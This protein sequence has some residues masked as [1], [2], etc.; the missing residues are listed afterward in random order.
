MIRKTILGAGTVLFSVLLSACQTGGAGA[1]SVSVE[2]AKRITAGF[3]G[4]YT[5]PPKSIDDIVSM[6]AEVEL[7]SEDCRERRNW[8]GD[9]V[10][11]IMQALP[12]FD[13][14]VWPDRS[15][16]AEGEAE[17]EFQKGNFP[18]SVK[19]MKWAIGAIPG[20][21]GAGR[22][23]RYAKLAIYHARAGDFESADEALSDALRYA[24]NVGAQ[25]T[26]WS[27][28]VGAT[29]FKFQ[30]DS[31]R[32]AILL[33]KGELARAEDLQRRGIEVVK[34]E[35]LDRIYTIEAVYAETDLAINLMRQG[36]LVEAESVARDVLRR[37]TSNFLIPAHVS[38]PV[39]VRLTQ[40]LFEQG[41]FGDSQTL[42]REA[43]KLYG[44]VCASEGSLGLAIARDVLGKSLVAQR[45]WQEALV[46]YEAIRQGLANDPETFRSKFAG[47][48]DWA[49]ALLYVG[50][51]D[52][53]ASMLRTALA[54]NE[55]RLGKKHYRTAEVRGFVAVVRAATGDRDGALRGFAAATPILLSR[56]READD[57][58]STFAIRDRR[59]QLILESYM[60][61]L[62]DN[63]GPAL[64]GGVDAAAEAF[65]LADA[66]RGRSVQRALSASAAR[67]AANDPA[68]ADLV[69]R[70]QDAQKQIAA[71]YGL[72]AN[73]VSLP[74]DEQNPKVVNNLRTRIDQLR[75]ARAAL[76]EEIDGRFPDYAELINPKPA[77]VADA[78]ASLSAGEAL[79][80]TYVGEDRSYVW[81]VPHRGDVAFAGIGLGR[82]D[83]ADTVALLRS[84]LE[85]NAATL[86]DIPDFDVAE[87]YG[88]Y[89]KLLKPVE[90]GWK[91]ADS[92]LVVAHGPLGYLP[93]SVLPTR[94]ADLGEEQE[95]LFS[96]YR[97]VPWLARNH[98]VTMLPSVASLKTLRGAAAGRSGP[99]GLRR[100]RRPLLQRRAGGG[101]ETDGK[102]DADC[103]GGDPELAHH[104][105]SG[106]PSG[107]AP[108]GRAGER[109][110]GAAS[111]P[112]G[113]RRRG[114]FHRRGAQRRP[115]SRCL[116]R[117][118]GQ[119]RRGED[120]RPVG[121]QGSCLRHPRP[122]HLNLKFAT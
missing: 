15:G 68:L 95:P 102:A 82:E 110:V 51:A 11:R 33:S 67:S 5:A 27:N 84:A 16:F 19:Y 38:A 119:R 39:L 104:G 78:R 32:A 37:T 30:V 52:E 48:L 83:L 24:G 122:S 53:A 18:R 20:E 31:G 57:E 2:E 62:A 100:L 116:L 109:G 80:A 46:Q 115:D 65:R 4:S 56:S 98:A 117:R 93:L 75:G 89:E 103:R 43:V 112:A 86:G 114:A 101:G 54:R 55:K 72:V 111:T 94:A 41:R 12:P 6:V 77:T 13:P 17:Y 76:M 45:R 8:S 69:R 81:A 36:R 113:Y 63:Q 28:P 96:N 49:V 21:Y 47:N 64:R 71:L 1:P 79:I 59:Q 58:S 25:A 99:Q 88:L 106:E 50:K 66:A 105:A 60:S 29:W 3:S 61:V 85:P 70:E 34:K 73:L 90:R 74:T 44:A 97:A 22:A 9:Q 40:I 42:A 118:A 7:P 91:D 121:I 108:D 10:Q 120:A 23:I 35:K 14:A 87:A 92:L 26:I 107:R